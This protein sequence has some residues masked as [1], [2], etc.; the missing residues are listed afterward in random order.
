MYLT[1]DTRAALLQIGQAIERSAAV[2]NPQAHA[3]VA[4]M[5]FEIL[6]TL[7]GEVRESLRAEQDDIS[8]YV[9]IL[10]RI[11]AGIDTPPEPF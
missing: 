10:N 5:M 3:G 4:K 11:E 7:C 1:E 9:A 6:P 8:N 2:N